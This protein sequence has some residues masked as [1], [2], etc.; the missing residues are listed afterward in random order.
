MCGGRQKRPPHH[1]YINYKT[2]LKPWRRE[3]MMR[4]VIRNS[5]SL[6]AVVCPARYHAARDL[7]PIHTFLSRRTNSE[8]PPRSNLLIRDILFT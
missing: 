8:F 4:T 6:R 2:I 1:A 3:L 7:S 5:G